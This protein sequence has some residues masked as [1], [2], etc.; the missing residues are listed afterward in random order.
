MAVDVKTVGSSGQI[1]L[2]EEYARRQVLVEEAEPR[3][4][5]VRTVA[6]IPDDERWLLA[7]EVAVGLSRALAWATE[8]PVAGHGLNLGAIKRK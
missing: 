2:G 6:V 3:A 5:M 4:W 1:S 7:P 8:N